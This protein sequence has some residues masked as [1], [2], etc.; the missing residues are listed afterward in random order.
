MIEGVENLKHIFL[1]LEPERSPV[2][3]VQATV[4][5]NTPLFVQVGADGSVG[6][7]LTHA[8]VLKKNAWPVVSAVLGKKL[9]KVGS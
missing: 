2:T 4:S 1:P 6:G 5:D 8:D 9:M 7:V 3:A